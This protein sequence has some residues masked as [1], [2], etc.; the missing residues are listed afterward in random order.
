MCVCLCDFSL[1]L[2]MFHWVLLYTLS[3]SKP[4]GI[5]VPSFEQK[6]YGS[7]H[8]SVLHFCALS[9]GASV[10]VAGA[11]KKKSK[12]KECEGDRCYKYVFYTNRYHWTGE[13]RNS[14]M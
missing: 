11:E 2:N 6:Q 5:C 13:E 14:K 4:P 8:S 7:W 3:A 9:T 12:T 1:A 10:T